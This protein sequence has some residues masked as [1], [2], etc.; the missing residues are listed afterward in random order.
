ML[1]TIQIGPFLFPTAGL[2]Y[3]LGAWLSLTTLERTAKRLNLDAEAVYG[4]GAT[5]VFAGLIGA[6]L[7]FVALYWPAFRQNPLGIIWPLTTGYN[8]WG[9]LMVGAA[10]AFF[11]GRLKRLAP[12]PTLDALTPGLMVALMAL[13][14]ADFLAGPGYGTLTSLPWGI[15][16][17]G[18]RRHPVQLYEIL[19]GLAALLLWWRLANHRLFA[20]QLFL[21][22]IAFYCGGRL[23]LDAFRANAWLTGSGFHILQ[24]IALAVMLVNLFL[25]ARLSTRATR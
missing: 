13:S 5:A 14:L 21:L 6:R 24:I 8:L 9:G 7:A 11:Y 12:A 1:P 20:G 15:S 19:L 16:L 18:V 4:L 2:I 3:L 23:F 25:L 22:T 10:A 17:F